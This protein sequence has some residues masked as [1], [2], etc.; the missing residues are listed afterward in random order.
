MVN[1]L[2]VK[3]IRDNKEIII[4]NKIEIYLRIYQDIIDMSYMFDNCE[5]LSS[6]TDISKNNNTL[7]FTNLC[8]MFTGCKLL[9]SLSDISKWK[10]NNVTDMS[11]IFYSC[12]SL[13]CLPD[14]S[15]WNTKNVINKK[16][17]FI[18]VKN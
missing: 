6:F 4:Y 15:K 11:Y 8:H 9:S 14:I 16:V 12:E 13:S 5:S 3:F 1:Y 7:I 2:V 17:F 10:T 18:I